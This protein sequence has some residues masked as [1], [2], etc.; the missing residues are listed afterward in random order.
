MKAR[1]GI[2]LIAWWND[3]LEELSDGVTLEECLRQASTA[4]FSGMETGRRFPLDMTVLA[5]ILARYDI[6]VCGGWYSGSLLEGDLDAEKENV[7]QQLDFFI[8]A[9]A[10]CL[11]YGEISRSIQGDRARALATKPVLAADDIKAYAHRVGEFSAWCAD[12]SMPLAFHHH[13]GAVIETEAELDIFMHHAGEGVSL[14]LDT[15]HL[16]MAGGDVQRVID[17]Y[18]ACIIHVHVKD[19]RRAVLAALDRTRASFL[20]AVVNGVFTV[21][22]DGS[23]DFEP[24]VKR[25]A[26]HGYEGWFVV[27]AEQDPTI[28][29]PL[30]MAHKGHAELIR[31]MSAAGYEVVR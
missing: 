16:V 20:D 7:R 29:P 8:A 26:A 30:E 6:A 28:N 9:K 14:T 10:P 4:G 23:L 25:L 31:V 22:G 18:H 5:P 13:V 24:I 2:A 3:D 12:Q 15:G 11:V 27:E 21:P 19:V 1:L 17:N